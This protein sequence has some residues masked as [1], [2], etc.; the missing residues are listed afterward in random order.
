MRKYTDEM[1]RFIKD[2]APGRWNT[3]LAKLFN[4]HFKTNF[5]LGAIIHKKKDM[6]VK[7]GVDTGKILI[8]V[9]VNTRF[10]KGGNPQNKFSLGTEILR[11][12]GYIW[13]KI[14]ETNPSRFGWIQKHR[15]I[16]EQHFGSIP[17][18]YQVM[19]KDQNKLNM[20][21]SNLILVTMAE[22]A[23]M[24]RNRLFSADSELNAAALTTSKIMLKIG[25]L[26]RGVK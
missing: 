13:V 24:S 6:K 12:D 26:A 21:P 4:D 14:K 17:E 22:K 5:S 1:C 2:N 19:F 16:Y 20:D 9:G 11:D 7:S 3:E 23:M 18:G 10:K 8:R 15:L 25:S